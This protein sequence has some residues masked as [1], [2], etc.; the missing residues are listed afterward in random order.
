MQLRKFTAKMLYQGS[1]IQIVEVRDFNFCEC[2]LTLKMQECTSRNEKC[3]A[4]M[5]NVDYRSGL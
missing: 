4:K 1:A 2:T 5:F 3:T